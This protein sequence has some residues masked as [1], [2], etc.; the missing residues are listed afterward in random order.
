M[1]IVANNI[2]N[3][4]TTGF[5]FESLMTKVSRPARPAFHAGRPEAGEVSVAR[6]TALARNFQ[7]GVACA[8]TDAKL[9]PRPIEGQGFFSR[10]NNQGRR[11]AR[12]T[13]ATA[14]SATDDTGRV[15]QARPATSLGR[16]RRA[17]RSPSTCRK[18]PARSPSPRRRW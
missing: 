6:R 5:K 3:A 14:T 15:D 9:D 8:A 12:Y 1:D 10:S 16:R 2:A 13:P 18:S 4:D 7:P 17:A 11:R